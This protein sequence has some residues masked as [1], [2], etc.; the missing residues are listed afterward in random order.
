MA[1]W[2]DHES[3]LIVSIT[4]DGTTARRHHSEVSRR[5]SHG[6]GPRSTS[7][8]AIWEETDRPSWK[9]QQLEQLQR[10]YRKLAS[11]L[12][13]ADEIAIYGPD[14]ARFELQTVLD[15]SGRLAARIR[16]IVPANWMTDRQFKVRAQADHDEWQ[17]NRHEDRTA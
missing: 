7:G 5:R 3:A 11:E 9:T 16:S 14:E 2:I 1:I 10:F 15:R 12:K 6:G 8:V 17:R 13:D 4:P